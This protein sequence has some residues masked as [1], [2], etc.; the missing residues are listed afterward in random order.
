MVRL[1]KSERLSDFFVLFMISYEFSH[2]YTID[3]FIEGTGEA[4]ITFPNIFSKLFQVIIVC[5]H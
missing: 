4:I 3:Y 5:P 2:L 1:S